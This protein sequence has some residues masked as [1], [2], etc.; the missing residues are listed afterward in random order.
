MTV[1]KRCTIASEIAKVMSVVHIEIQRAVPL[2]IGPLP[3]T[4]IMIEHGAEQ[5]QE[6]D[7]G[8]DRPSHD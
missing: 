3:R 6:G 7:D 4:M 1:S 2:A 8:E 5:R